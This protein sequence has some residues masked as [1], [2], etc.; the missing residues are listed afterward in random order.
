MQRKCG[1]ESGG[2]ESP[3]GRAGARAPGTK[4]HSRELSEASGV[5]ARHLESM[6]AL[7]SALASHGPTCAPTQYEG[8]EGT[9]D[10]KS[11]VPVAG[12]PLVGNLPLQVALLEVSSPPAAILKPTRVREH[13][14]G[15]LLEKLAAETANRFKAVAVAAGRLMQAQNFE[16]IWK[17]QMSNLISHFGTPPGLVCPHASS[18]SK[19]LQASLGPTDQSSKSKCLQTKNARY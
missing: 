11:G 7:Y 18:K 9:C 5:H 10:L 16:R 8:G 14:S 4:S 12:S 6:R 1:M 3:R 15:F 13:L 2:W 17:I 19:Y